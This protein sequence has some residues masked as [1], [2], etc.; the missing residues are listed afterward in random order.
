MLHMQHEVVHLR[1]AMVEADPGSDTLAGELD[2]PAVDD[3]PEELIAKEK[4]GFLDVITDVGTHRQFVELAA[5]N[6][7]PVIC[8]KPM[9][10]TLADAEAMVAACRKAGVPFFVNE[11]WRW[12][13][14]LRELRRILA[15]DQIGAVFRGRIDY[16]N[17]FPVFDN[18]PFLK[19]L[20][21]IE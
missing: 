16:C 9:A 12:Q 7:I 6:R 20:A 21:Q 2:V 3:N 19:N 15:S 8:Q 4:P 11:N 14:P 18:Q 17:S 5:A 10:P 1:S 13:T